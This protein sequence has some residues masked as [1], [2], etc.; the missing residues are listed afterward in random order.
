M[1]I[2]GEFSLFI[3]FVLKLKGEPPSPSSSSFLPSPSPFISPPPFSCL[4]L[5]FDHLAGC[6]L[7]FGIIIAVASWSC[8]PRLF[9]FENGTMLFCHSSLKSERPL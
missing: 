7:F 1:V 8:V 5:E 6:Y 9:R 2:G 3:I 4:I